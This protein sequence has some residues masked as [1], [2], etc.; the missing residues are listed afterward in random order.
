L[1]FSAQSHVG[2]SADDV[3]VLEY[4]KDHWEKAGPLK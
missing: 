4:K 2:L 1:H 3:A